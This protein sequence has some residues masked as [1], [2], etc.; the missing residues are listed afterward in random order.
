MTHK[1]GEQNV[2]FA[3]ATTYRPKHLDPSTPRYNP[4]RD[5]VNCARLA[6]L[7]MYYLQYEDSAFWSAAA[8]AFGINL[9]EVDATG[10]P[11]LSPEIREA[12]E[13]FVHFLCE[14]KGEGTADKYW[15]I[16]S[17]TDFA[18]FETALLN[19]MRSD[20]RGLAVLF[21]VLGQA[22]LDMVFFGVRQDVLTGEKSG[23]FTIDDLWEVVPI[24]GAML[25]DGREP[26]EFAESY[27]RQATS[28]ALGAGMSGKQIDQIVTDQV[29]AKTASVK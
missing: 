16:T 24:Y 4:D 29:V 26:T 12:Y 21:G 1:L 3:K 22:L 5:F 25:R 20:H 7:V 10:K 23:N 17:P 19:L 2:L 18:S 9:R 8:N 6:N 14:A 15:K 28:L 27:L 11:R 13:G